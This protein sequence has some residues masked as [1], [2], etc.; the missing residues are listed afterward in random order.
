MARPAPLLL[1]L[2]AVCLVAAASAGGADAAER[3]ATTVGVYELRK[4]DFSI[5][6]TNWGAVIMSVVL[7]DS[8][9]KL[10]DVVLG[11]DTIAEYVVRFADL[12]V[13][14]LLLRQCIC[15]YFHCLLTCFYTQLVKPHYIAIVPCPHC[16]LI[17]IVEQH[18]I[19]IVCVFEFFFFAL[20]SASSLLKLVF[21]CSSPSFNFT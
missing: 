19:A 18:Y 11:Y 21:C 13:P 9:G 15:S 3:K 14:V 17:W 1:L 8:R 20:L 4:G 6:V 12:I 10:D 7:P 2:A 5:R 16:R